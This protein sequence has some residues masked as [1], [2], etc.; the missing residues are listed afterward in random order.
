MVTPAC[1]SPCSF[2]NTGPTHDAGFHR[3]FRLESHSSVA[4]AETAM[5]EDGDLHGLSADLR[6]VTSSTPGTL[7]L[8]T[9][10]NVEGLRVRKV[11]VG[12][13]KAVDQ[14]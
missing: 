9:N 3:W 6:R 8:R 11:C 13:A 10:V 5:A 4:L 14:S 1:V 7:P 12:T 2:P